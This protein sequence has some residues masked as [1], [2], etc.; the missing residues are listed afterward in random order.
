MGAAT[1][2]FK[3]CF[4]DCNKAFQFS[5]VCANP[6]TSKMES[7]YFPCSF[8]QCVFFCLKEGSVG[9]KRN[10]G[11]PPFLFCSFFSQEKTVHRNWKTVKLEMSHFTMIV[12][13]FAT[14]AAG[15]A[16]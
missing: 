12:V 6:A 4:A 14:I 10:I 16:I 9:Q 13:M 3:K 1:N 8:V 5:G 15:N 11:S 7:E 2:Y